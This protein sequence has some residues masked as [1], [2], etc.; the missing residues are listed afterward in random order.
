[1]DAART[2][3]VETVD[4]RSNR[5]L[6][7]GDHSDPHTSA[8][9]AAL[10]ARHW[11]A[12]IVDIWSPWE[13]FTCSIGHAGPSFERNGRALYFDAIW[14][15][16]KPRLAG[17][18]GDAEAFV[19]RE[20]TEFLRACAF[21]AE[22]MP[23]INNP[24]AIDRARNKPLQLLT[25]QSVGWTIPKTWISSEAQLI[26]QRADALGELV[27]KPLSWLATAEGK[28]LF[29]NSLNAREIRSAAVQVEG[30]PGIFQEVVPKRHEYRITVVDENC[31]SARIH[32]QELVD[33]KLDW[34]RR[35]D[36]V[37]YEACQL[38]ELMMSNALALTRRLGLRYAAI[39][40]IER[41]DGEIVFLEAN[42]SGNWL[43]LEER[44]GLPIAAAIA[45][46]LSS[47]RSDAGRGEAR[48]YA[49]PMV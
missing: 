38:N 8:V 47:G 45:S 41:P 6:V 42:P 44:V 2:S 46:A 9:V 40:C 1:M 13:S 21:A 43:W 37:R 3:T 7:V 4:S 49:R 35:V 12:E 11:A 33:A 10:N 34:R 15:R 5:V 36:D 25:A 23:C 30:A 26:A 19:L 18:L 31:F 20:R 28:I 29:T 14:W 39:D 27:Y 17:S 16:A 48:L 22:A 32:S 24:W